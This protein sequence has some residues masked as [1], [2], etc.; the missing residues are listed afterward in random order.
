MAA[1]LSM[2]LTA[3]CACGVS[4]TD[5]ASVPKPAI[6]ASGI[7][8]LTAED[9]VEIYE[10]IA[11]YNTTE[12]NGDIEGWVDTYTVDGNFTGLR[13]GNSITGHDELRKFATERLKRPDRVSNAHWSSNITITPTAE[14]AQAQSY[15]LIV[16]RLP[17][18]TLRMRSMASKL[19]EL[20]KENGRW[21]FKSRINKPWPDAPP[22]LPAH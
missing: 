12:D 7:S 15:V 11:R 1:T 9:R 8:A 2:V 4:N 13:Q 21:K 14:G 22:A 5:N 20:R 17:D 19:D 6:E 16:E 10:L 18:G 3:L